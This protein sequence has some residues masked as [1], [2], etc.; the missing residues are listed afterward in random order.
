MADETETAPAEPVVEASSAD[1]TP[2]ASSAVS[3]EAPSASLAQAPAEQPPDEIAPVTPSEAISEPSVASLEPEVAD[4]AAQNLPVPDPI[5]PFAPQGD[6]VA[7]VAEVAEPAPAEFAAAGEPETS[8]PI[9]PP[10][11]EPEAHAVPASLT[12]TPLGDH[13]IVEDPDTHS[14]YC[15]I[16][17]SAE[18]LCT[19]KPIY[20]PRAA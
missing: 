10:T 11:A 8:S 20:T 2:E 13:R 5:P 1:A 15:E 12:V 3:E 19:E 17:L 18:W 14:R 9:L 7:P 16:C 6:E 4:A